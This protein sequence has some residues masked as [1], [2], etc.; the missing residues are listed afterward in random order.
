MLPRMEEA[1]IIEDYKTKIQELSE[2]LYR[3]R[4]SHTEHRRLHLQEMTELRSRY[5]NKKL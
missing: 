2:E 1:R 3:Q 4:C 5:I